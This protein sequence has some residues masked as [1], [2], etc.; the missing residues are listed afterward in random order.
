MFIVDRAQFIAWTQGI[1]FGNHVGSVFAVN[2]VNCQEAENRLKNGEKIGLTV[3]GELK[4][5]MQLIDGV[6]RE[7]LFN[8]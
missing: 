1:L 4:T 7:Q 3:K 5:T 8:D 6:F 2:E